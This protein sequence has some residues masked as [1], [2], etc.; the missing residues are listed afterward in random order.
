MFKG[1]KINE[2]L[3]SLENLG[4]GIITISKYS[5]GEIF[6]IVYNRPEIVQV[7]GNKRIHFS[8]G[9]FDCFFENGVC[10]SES[11]VLED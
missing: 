8:A 1:M 7:D 5:D 9:E 3:E 10:E 4:Y 11:R 2:V 6:S